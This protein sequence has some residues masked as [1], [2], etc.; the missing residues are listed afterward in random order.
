MIMVTM[1]TYHDYGHDTHNVLEY[2]KIMMVTVVMMMV[3]MMATISTFVRNNHGHD[4]GQDANIYVNK[5]AC[6]LI[7]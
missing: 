4:V 3:T 2:F 5:L 6:N 7:L 1:Q